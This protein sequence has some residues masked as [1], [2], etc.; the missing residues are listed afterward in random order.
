MALLFFS[1]AS[2]QEAIYQREDIYEPLNRD[3]RDIRVISL[4]PS[5]SSHLLGCDLIRTSLVNQLNHEKLP[6]VWDDPD[7]VSQIG[8]NGHELRIHRSLDVALRHIRLKDSPMLL[9]D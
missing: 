2:A 9:V 6:Y 8:F 3:L 7:L 5:D 1:M 4:H